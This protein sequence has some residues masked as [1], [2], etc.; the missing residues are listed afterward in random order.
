[1]RGRKGP[2]DT[3]YK[4]GG[5]GGGKVL[6]GPDGGAVLGS[7]GKPVFAAPGSSVGTLL[8]VNEWEC[9]CHLVAMLALS[10]E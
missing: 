3:T 2:H 4:G 6:L 7:D 5:G 9:P 1:M 8:R 10:R